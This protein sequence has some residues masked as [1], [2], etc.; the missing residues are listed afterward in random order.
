MDNMS[1]WTTVKTK[2]N[3]QSVVRKALKRM[4]LEAQEG[5]FTI[6]QYGTSEKAQLMIDE[7]VGLSRQKDGSFAMVGDFWHS[8]NRALKGYYGRNEKFVEDLSTAYAVEEAFTNLEDQNFF[9]TENENGTV[10]ED[11]FITLTYE[12]YS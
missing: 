12:R 11:G 7:A 2:L 9:C 5:D 3:N 8:K 6:T 1:H 10:G 4:G